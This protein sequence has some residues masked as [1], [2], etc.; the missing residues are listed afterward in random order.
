MQIGLIR[1]KSLALANVEGLPDWRGKPPMHRGLKQKPELQW[2]ALL[3]LTAPDK[4]KE[5]AD[6]GQ[7]PSSFA[8]YVYTDF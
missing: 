5:A 8:G 6:S 1:K 3:L 4:M 7:P 2:T